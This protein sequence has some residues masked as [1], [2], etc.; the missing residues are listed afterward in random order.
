MDQTESPVRHSP[1]ARLHAVM[2]LISLCLPPGL[3]GCG[4]P[5]PGASADTAPKQ[6]SASPQNEAAAKDLLTSAGSAD[7]AGPASRIRFTPLPADRFPEIIPRRGEEAGYATILESLGSGAAAADLDRDGL[8]DALVAGGGSFEG[9]QPIGK[10][11]YV[12]RNRRSHFSDHTLTAGLAEISL[13]HHGLAVADA[14]N[15][16]FPDLLVSG[17]GGVLYFRNQGDGTFIDE[18]AAAGLRCPTWC[19][20]AAWADFNRDGSLDLYVAGYVDWSFE[21]DPPCFA[22][23]AVT[24]DNCSPKLFNPC[25]DFLLISQADGTWQ[26]QTQAWGVRPDGKAL[27]V[28][29]ADLDRDGW[30]DLYVGNDVMINFL[31]RNAG[32]QQFEDRS[33]SS[34]AGVSS[35]GSPDASMGVDAADYDNDGRFDL[36]A[37]NFEM[38][39]FA[40][41]RNQGSMMFRHISDEAGIAAVGA[42]YV[43]WGTGFGDFDLDGDEDLAVCNG[44]VV[45]FPQHSPAKQRMLLLE[46][47]EQAWFREATATAG[48]S[49]MQQVNGRGLALLDWNLDGRLDLLTTPVES[50]AVLLQNETPHQGQWLTLILSGTSSPRHPVGCIVE[51]RTDQRTLLRQLKG[52]GSYA[53][54]HLPW[55][56]FGLLAD[57]QP[58]ELTIH[59][60]SGQRQTLDAGD[61]NSVRSIQEP[62]ADGRDEGIARKIQKNHNFD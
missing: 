39:S 9:K 16:G 7:T 17:Y 26:D 3:Q 19:S 14:D 33:I 22:A 15:D 13:Y 37:A 6:S 43:G 61:I 36:W 62:A 5:P 21:N 23:D 41:Y 12:L 45:R 49:L 47:I 31:Y 18:T 35:R 25:P 59:W 34:G 24:R 1:A 11:V 4:S 53:S 20:S 27:G 51:L 40:L 48:Q 46:N 28:V 52:G 29:A 56:H 44:N 55:L 42:H 60:P 54:T 10:P 8:P 38:E 32:G 57:E 58:L 2:L 50:P 30:T